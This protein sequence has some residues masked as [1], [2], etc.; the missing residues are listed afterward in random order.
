MPY[1]EKQ[2]VCVKKLWLK[3][4]TQFKF[5]VNGNYEVSAEYEQVK[6]NTNASNRTEGAL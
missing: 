6:V 4:E 3:E 2:R 1:D 5:I